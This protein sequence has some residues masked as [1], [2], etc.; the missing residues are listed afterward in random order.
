V[1]GSGGQS[2]NGTTH[3][4][5]TPAERAVRELYVGNTPGFVTEALLANF[6]GA[7]CVQVKISPENPVT[8]VRLNGKFCFVEFKTPE[9]ASKALHLNQIEFGGNNL[10]VSR[11]S[12]YHGPAMHQVTWNELLAHGIDAV[13][14]GASGMPDKGKYSK[15][16]LFRKM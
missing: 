10:R 1:A 11:P 6:I 7:A 12:S 3:S 15:R 13:L 9:I 5:T 8:N 16:T 2:A 14:Q 4:A